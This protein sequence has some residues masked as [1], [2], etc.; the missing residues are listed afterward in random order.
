MK[1]IQNL[2]V[3][4]EIH[5]HLDLKYHPLPLNYCNRLLICFSSYMSLQSILNLEWPFHTVN[6]IMP[7]LWWQPSTLCPF[8][9]ELQCSNAV[10]SISVATSHVQLLLTLCACFKWWFTL[11]IKYTLRKLVWQKRMQNISLIAYMLIT[12]R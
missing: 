9:L 8:N 6:Q 1:H 10:L 12:L 5:Y 3:F 2:T 4:Y 11:S 7:H